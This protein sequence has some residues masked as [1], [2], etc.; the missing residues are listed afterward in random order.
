MSVE[1]VLALA[2]DPA[3]RKAGADLA[4]PVKW[5]VLGTA[6]DAVWGEIKGSGKDPYRVAAAADGSASKCTCPSRKFPCKHA[7]GILAIAAATPEALAAEPPATL[8]RW[9]EDWINGRSAR[10]EAAVRRASE[11]PG[12]IDPKAKA[13]RQAARDAKVDA[14]IG[15]LDLWL[16]DLIRRGTL[17]ARAEP[18]ATF[19]RMAS[20]LVDAQATG[21][22]RRVRGLAGLIA[23]ASPDGRERT[24]MA[25][26]RLALLVR[27]AAR[28]DGLD[29]ELRAGL[30]AAIGY[31]TTADDLA[32]LPVVEDRWR[33][34][35]QLSEADDKI[36]TRSTWLIG[37][38]TALIALI[39]DFAA[40]GS[41]MA[42]GLPCGQALAGGLVFH[43]GAPGFRASRRGGLLQVPDR[44]LVPGAGSVAAAFGEVA[45]ILARAPWTDRFPVRL[46]DV[47]LGR[48]A[49]GF[50]ASDDTGSVPF[51]AA[52]PVAQIVSVAGGRP[53]ALFGL[54]DGFALLPMAMVVAG[55]H[56]A[57]RQNGDE[58]V[59]L[60][61]AA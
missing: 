40:G 34:Q 33:V 6:T 13:K 21:L 26:G 20:R 25:L 8:P 57:V 9:V 27:A 36:T 5:L 14:G 56:Y 24:A 61:R 10:A 35:A 28:A 15:E 22:A 18:Y 16:R 41:G 37:E 19:D 11:E 46:A 7:L 59:H 55:R 58:A 32:G 47:R 38:A 1:A 30:M 52:A 17:A 42:R 44:A 29:A 2:P 45:A 50:G 60:W 4:K 54:W 23:D 53:A 3:S 12:G 49:T 48:T 39:L 31:S 51:A 43:P